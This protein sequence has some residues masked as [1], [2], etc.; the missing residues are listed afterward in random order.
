MAAEPLRQSACEAS[1]SVC[2]LLVAETDSARPFGAAS[3]SPA[4]TSFSANFLRSFAIFGLIT[5]AQYG[6]F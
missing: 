2:V 5:A 6:W 1:A 3:Y 4:A